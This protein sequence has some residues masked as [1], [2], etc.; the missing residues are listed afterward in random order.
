MQIAV[1][2]LG[3]LG[4]E[5]ALRLKRQGHKVI[6]WNRG[7]ERAEGARQRGLELASS[8]AEAVAASELALLLL[9]DAAAI[10]ETL[11]DHGEPPELMDK[12]LV[13]M[14]TIGP[15]ESRDLAGQ[16]SA[17]GGRYLEA[18]VLGSL[19]EAREG[20][21]ILMAGGDPELFA[22]LQP[23]FLDLSPDPQHIGAVGQAAVLKLAMNQ[24]IAGLTAT[25]ALSLGL[26]RRAGIDT[27][28]FM[29]LL[30]TSA[31]YAKTFDKKLANYLAHDYRAANF[32]LK[33]LHKDIALFARTATA[34]GLETGLSEAIASACYR[35]EAMGL[36]EGDYS[37][38]YEALVP[39]REE[40]ES[41]SRFAGK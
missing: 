25:F 11:F 18:P 30:R 34:L 6:G 13:Q 23:V 10:R 26:V 27:E 40:S 28:Q 4:A 39:N 12:V 22:R 2:G 19:P 36:G 17:A 9:S 16:V 32:P 8:P 20:R 5:V 15:N 7:A 35:A 41:A 33:H 14:G 38:L 31:L 3:L 21:L 29:R 24:L 37:A 1:L